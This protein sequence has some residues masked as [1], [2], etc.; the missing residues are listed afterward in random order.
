[1]AIIR[2]DHK[3]E[4]QLMPE[5]YIK[6]LRFTLVLFLYRLLSLAF[7]TRIL[8]RIAIA[9]A[10]ILL[11]IN[12]AMAESSNSYFNEGYEKHLHGDL[13]GAVKWY[14][15]AIDKN[16]AF[17]MAY[18]MRGVA[19]QQRK[20]Y[21]QAINDYTMVINCGEPYFKAVGYYNRGVVKNMS[22][23]YAEAISDFSLAI[24]L[25]KRLAAAFFHRGIAKSKTGDLS[26]RFEDF[27]QAAK[28]GDTNAET[29]LNTYVPEWKKIPLT[30][31]PTPAAPSSTGNP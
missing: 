30:P 8:C 28:L 15:K 21:A 11:G 19:E 10:I 23:D 20:K 26:G 16:P 1:M 27:R 6:P 7:M 18:Q 24:E 2:Y 9:A 29:W 14:S 3:K 17:A 4:E 22:G 13:S 25:D 5:N 12:I 31:V